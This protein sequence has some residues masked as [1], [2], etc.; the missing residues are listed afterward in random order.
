M[1]EKCVDKKVIGNYIKAL[2]IRKD[3]NQE[4]LAFRLNISR[5]ALSKIETGT[6]HPS[7]DTTARLRY[8]FNVDVN[9]LLDD[10]RLLKDT[11]DDNNE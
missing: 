9:A 3:F 5:E 2:R 4:E 6:H 8:L 7:F 11:F 10:A 1:K